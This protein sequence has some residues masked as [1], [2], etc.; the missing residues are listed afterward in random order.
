[1]DFFDREYLISRILCGQLKWGVFTMYPPNLS[2]QYECQEIFR[3]SLEEGKRCGMISSE[4]LI[5]LSIEKGFIEEKDVIFLEIAENEIEQFQKELY[6]NRKKDDAVKS[7]RKMIYLNR[8]RHS[9]I[10][11]IVNKHNAFTYEGYA[12]HCKLDYL[13]RQIT[14]KEKKKCKFKKE[15]IESAINHYIENMILPSTLRYLSRTQPWVNM[16]SA[17][18]VNGIIFPQGCEMTQ[19]Q[20]LL[21]MWSKMY[22]SIHESPDCPESFVFDDDDMLDGWLLVQQEQNKTKEKVESK[23]SQAQEQYIIANNIDE[24]K[25]IENRNS[26][27]VLKIKKQRNKA[28]QE[29]G[30][31]KEADLPDVKRKLMIEKN[32]LSLERNGK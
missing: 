8:A 28:I 16:W 29:K 13:I 26:P 2:I 17:F 20:Q 18:K 30:E 21:L 12:N 9:K 19:Q 7:I 6:H 27:D 32:R 15:K 10:L 22:D 23:L 3:E 1:M 24:A 11:N 5:D 14:F 4:D 31:L 25:E